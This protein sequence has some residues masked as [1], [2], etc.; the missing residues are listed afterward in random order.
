MAYVTAISQHRTF[1]GTFDVAP[2]ESGDFGYGIIM[3]IGMMDELGIDQSRTTKITWGELE[4][5]MVPS[6][7]WTDGRIQ[8]VCKVTEAK[9]L[10]SFSKDEENNRRFRKSKAQTNL[11]LFQ[12]MVSFRLLTNLWKQASRRQFTRR[13][14]FFKSQSATD[15]TSLRSSK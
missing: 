15:P 3:G 7:Y 4:T 5:P 8:T 1:E 10:D 2:P 14:I 9:V 11:P 13:W 12:A 6:R